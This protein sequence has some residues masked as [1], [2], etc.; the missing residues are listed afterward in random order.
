LRQFDLENRLMRYP[1]SY[2]IYSDAFK[3]LNADAKDAIFKR[4]WEVLSGQA[5]EKKYSRLSSD[6]R[7]AVIEILH[8]TVPDLPAFFKT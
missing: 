2:M 1:C 7:K 3:A 5:K 6:D 4:M 8:D